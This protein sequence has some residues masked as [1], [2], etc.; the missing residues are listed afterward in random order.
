M[1]IQGKLAEG[2]SMISLKM[3]Q[4]CV[5]TRGLKLREILNSMAMVLRSARRCDRE[6]VQGNASDEKEDGAVLALW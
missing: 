5:Y 4:P 3:H 1:A 2:F 6:C